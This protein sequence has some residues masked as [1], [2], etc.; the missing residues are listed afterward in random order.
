MAV[1]RTNSTQLTEGHGNGVCGK[2]CSN[3]IEEE[4]HMKGQRT[5][6]MG[7]WEFYFVFI[8]H[9]RRAWEWKLQLTGIRAFGSARLYITLQLVALFVRRRHGPVAEDCVY[10]GR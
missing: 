5:C 2:F 10:M 4:L 8:A 6:C 1:S 7:K 3:E 9:L